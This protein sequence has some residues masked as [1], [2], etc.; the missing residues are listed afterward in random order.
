M[1]EEKEEEL[2]YKEAYTFLFNSLTEIS[3]EIYACQRT[4][5]EI[6]IGDKRI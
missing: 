2:N 4:A 3:K 6:A 1:Q 5:E